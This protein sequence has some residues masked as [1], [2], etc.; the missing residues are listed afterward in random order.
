MVRREEA[1]DGVRDAAMIGGGLRNNFIASVA[2]SCSQQT[3]DACDPH[4]TCEPVSGGE[5]TRENEK[6]RVVAEPWVRGS[7]SLA[8]PGEPEF[9]CRGRSDGGELF[10]E[11]GIVIGGFIDRWPWGYRPKGPRLEARG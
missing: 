1:Q 5:D 6:E 9:K 11:D 4:A 8:L 10:F 7:H 2:S 3:L